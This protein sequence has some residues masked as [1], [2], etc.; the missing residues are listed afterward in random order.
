VY[1]HPDPHRQRTEALLVGALTV[2]LM[3]I[4]AIITIIATAFR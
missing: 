3:T 2:L 4:G 1:R